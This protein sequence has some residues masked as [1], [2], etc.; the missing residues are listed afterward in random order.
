M[1]AVFI[2]HDNTRDCVVWRLW[3]N[4]ALPFTPLGVERDR[5]A[6]LGVSVEVEERVQKWSGP[7]MRKRSRP[8][9]AE[10]NLECRARFPKTLCL[11]TRDSSVH[12]LG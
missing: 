4:L 2:Y 5:R 10:H 12:Q 11:Y 1:W 3:T 9:A 8:M 7:I 6:R